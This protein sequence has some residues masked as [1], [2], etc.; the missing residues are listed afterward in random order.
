MANPDRFFS[1]LCG[2]PSSHTSPWEQVILPL[3]CGQSQAGTLRGCPS[4][5][6]RQETVELGFTVPWRKW[7]E[8]CQPK[9]NWKSPPAVFNPLIK[10]AADLIVIPNISHT[11]FSKAAAEPIVSLAGCNDLN[12]S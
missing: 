1:Q 8:S 7:S 2:S 5:S 11:E 4:S 3:S 9:A 10:A 6:S 12:L